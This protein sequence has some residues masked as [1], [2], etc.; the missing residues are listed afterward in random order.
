MSRY[1]TPFSL[2]C[3]LG[4]ETLELLLFGERLQG[5]WLPRRS[6]TLQGRELCREAFLSFKRQK[7][8]SYTEPF[9][10]GL[11]TYEKRQSLTHGLLIAIDGKTRKNSIWLS[12]LF[13]FISPHPP[14]D[15]IWKPVR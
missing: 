11:L 8:K 10:F 7:Q 1:S 14:V 4:G 3:C 13:G 9:S 2:L 12:Y 6:C 15:L 5:S